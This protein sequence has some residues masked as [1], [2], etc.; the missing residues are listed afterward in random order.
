VEVRNGINGP[1]IVPR[2]PDR[3]APR[4]GAAPTIVTYSGAPVL[5]VVAAGAP[6]QNL[7]YLNSNVQKMATVSWASDAVFLN[8]GHNDAS[9]IGRAYWTALD[10]WLAAVRG[11]GHQNV[12]VIKQN[13]Q[14]STVNTSVQHALRQGDVAAWAARN[15]LSAVDVFR[16]FRDDA[17]GLTALL[18]ADGIHPTDAAGSPLWAST[19]L[20]GLNA[21]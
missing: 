20:A 14:A 3:W 19:F 4:Y 21:G 15:A 6:G 8:I 18:D 11:K 2:Y 13:P 1:R 9:L 10:T 12:G 7:A 16:A 17:R 5:T